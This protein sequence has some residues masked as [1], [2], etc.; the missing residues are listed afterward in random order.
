MLDSEHDIPLLVS[1]I[2]IPVR[3]DDLLE[4]VDAVNHWFERV[5][6]Q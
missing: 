3:L 4:R 1:L 5:R 2:H 6:F